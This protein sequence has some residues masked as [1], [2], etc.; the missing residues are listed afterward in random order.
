MAA[1]RNEK[2]RRRLPRAVFAPQEGLKAILTLSDNLLEQRAVQIMNI[3]R[4]GLGLAIKKN[5]TIGIEK[6]RLFFLSEIH[7]GKRN[8]IILP[9]MELKVVWIIEHDYLHNIGFGCVFLNPN[10]RNIHNIIDF[11]NDNFPGR[12]I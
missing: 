2:E 12:L 7:S 10:E 9:S 11:I 4:S 5:E 6:G 1:E 3:S 8:S